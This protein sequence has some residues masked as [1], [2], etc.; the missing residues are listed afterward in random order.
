MIM[1]KYYR[2]THTENRRSQIDGLYWIEKKKQ[3]RIIQQQQYTEPTMCVDTINYNQREY[4]KKIERKR[5]R[6][7]VS[8]Y[9]EQRK[10]WEA[11]MNVDEVDE[12]KKQ[13]KAIKERW[14][15]HME[16]SNACMGGWFFSIAFPF[17]IDS[18]IRIDNNS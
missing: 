8:E 16:S 6:L 3:K 9:K 14:C 5:E 17:R 12:K 10:N 2:N 15:E 7:N 1:V 4:E 11:I 13:K 18:I